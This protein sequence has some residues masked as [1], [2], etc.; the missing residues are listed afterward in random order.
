MRHS[1]IL[2]LGAAL[3]L[4]ACNKENSNAAD[5]TSRNQTD[6]T[7]QPTAPPTPMDQQNDATDLRITQEIRTAIVDKSELSMNAHNVK[8][9]T[10]NGVVTLRG[11]VDS[12][13]E[14]DTIESIAVAVA[15]VTR[16]DNQ[17]EVKSGV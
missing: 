4:S 15:G 14:R 2:A 12:A 8:V 1:V 17:L 3:A 9:I 11:P 6:R 7:A 16:V 5:N 13:A 10:E